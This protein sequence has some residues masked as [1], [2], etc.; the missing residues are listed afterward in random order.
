MFLNSTEIAREKFNKSIY[1]AKDGVKSY[2]YVP[3]GFL[4]DN[5]NTLL[6]ITARENWIDQP[7]YYEFQYDPNKF[8]QI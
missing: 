1:D 2:L 3:F 6:Q 7:L 8:Y 5:N 4:M